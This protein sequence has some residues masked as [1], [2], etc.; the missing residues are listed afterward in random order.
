MGVS[1]YIKKE[2]LRKYEKRVEAHMLVPFQKILGLLKP[3]KGKRI[4]DIGSGSGELTFEIAK[5]GGKVVGVDKSKQWVL[6]CKKY[7]HANLTFLHADAAKKLP[8]R[9]ATFD[10]VVMNMVLLNVATLREVETVFKEVS[11]L[12]K[13]TGVF[14]FSD[15]HPICMMTPNVPPIRYQKYPKHFSY[16]RDGEEFTAGVRLGGHEKI[17]FSDKHWTLET[18]TDLLQKHGLYIYKIAEPTYGK[19]AP[20]LLR[21]FK[22]PEYIL[23]GCKKLKP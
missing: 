1:T 4:L 8:F 5:A 14:I 6:H 19:N 16:F 10:A 18:Y 2:F 11:R 3:I 13:P 17:E 9:T 21:K 23:F 12:L 7:T 15:L 22:I 20:A